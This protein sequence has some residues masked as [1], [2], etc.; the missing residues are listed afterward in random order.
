[1]RRLHKIQFRPID[2]HSR[3]QS[4]SYDKLIHS[5]D[6]AITNLYEAPA[7]NRSVRLFSERCTGTLK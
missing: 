2:R 5:V 3:L 1:M 6:E 4:P 7:A